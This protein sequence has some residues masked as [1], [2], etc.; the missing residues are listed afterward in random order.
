MATAGLVSTGPSLISYPIG[1]IREVATKEKG[2]LPDNPS[3][4][5]LSEVASEAQLTARYAFVVAYPIAEHNK[6]PGDQ[7]RP[8]PFFLCV[9]LAVTVGCADDQDA[10]QLIE[11]TGKLSAMTKAKD[12]A[13]EQIATLQFA[14]TAADNRIAGLSK[15]LGAADLQLTEDRETIEKLRQ[16][17]AR[18]K[19]RLAAAEKAAQTEAAA[20]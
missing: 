4:W 3:F 11:T 7:V 16:E 14:A 6:F 8:L 1:A 19:S 20:K 18:L 2:D 10:T 9:F 12:V 17:I 15:Q 13:E 5:P